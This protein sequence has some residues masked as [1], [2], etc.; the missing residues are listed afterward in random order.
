MARVTG[1]C[2]Y[3][4]EQFFY[5]LLRAVY[6]N[7]SDNDDRLVIGTVPLLVIRFQCLGLEVIYNLHLAD[8]HAPT[9][10]AAR[11]K[12]LEITFEQSRRGRRAQSPFLMNNAAFLVYLFRIECQCTRPVAENEQTGV[13][14]R[15]S[16]CRHVVDIVHCAVDRGIG[17]EVFSELH[18]QRFEIINNAIARKMSRTI[19]AVCQSPLVFVF[20]YGTHTLHDVKVYPMFGITV[21]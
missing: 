17:I 15:G 11:V 9:V 5:F 4:C 20:L 8:R 18:A 7:I 2:L 12:C 21:V 13:E 16:D 3:R 6:I 10:F 14:R 19:K 1:S